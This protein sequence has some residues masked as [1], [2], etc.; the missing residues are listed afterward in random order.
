MLPGMEAFGPP[1]GE[2][3][4]VARPRL[5]PVPS[6]A[7]VER[8]RSHIVYSPRC[9]FYVG[10]VSSPDG[11]T[12]VTWRQD[13][14]QFSTSGHRF[15]LAIE[16]GIADPTVVCE[17]ACNEPLCVR[18]DPEHVHPSTQAANVRYAVST[19]RHRGPLATGDGRSR[20]QR[21]R[22]VRDALAAG[23]DPERYAAAAGLSLTAAQPPLF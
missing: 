12:R 14:Q 23:W 17:H 22:D 7:V 4:S 18:I 3:S 5:L 2:H 13:G 8:F 21:S 20:V 16:T 15:A 1:F 6:D 9:H 19:G 10:A 11:Y